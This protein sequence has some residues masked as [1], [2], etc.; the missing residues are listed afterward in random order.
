VSADTNTAHQFW[1]S[2]KAGIYLTGPH[3]MARFDK[4]VGK[5]KFE[6]LPPPAGPKGNASL[7]E[8]SNVY[9]MAG[10]DNEA[11]Q[12]KFAEF[13]AS[14]EGQEIGMAGDTDG[15][16]V[17]IPINSK[18]DMYRTRKDR[19]WE[20]LKRIYDES[21]VYAPTV[22]DWTPF[23]QWSADTLNALA[24]DCSADPRE[25]MEQLSERFDA[26]LQKQ[27]IRAG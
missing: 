18:V 12:K 25:R 5:D 2:G 21:G 24:A 26:E 1:E 19:R 6:V 17:R 20:V 4:R 13:A 11:G 14:V 22:K 9:L 7:A 23:R 8:G 10:S 27:G 16:I 15:L 3:L